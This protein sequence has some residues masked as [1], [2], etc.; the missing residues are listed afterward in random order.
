MTGPVFAPTFIENQWVYLHRTVGS[1][2]KLIPIPSHFYKVII[3]RR[4]NTNNQVVGAFLV[5][6][7]DTV[8]KTVSG[9]LTQTLLTSKM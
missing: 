6:N 5:P 8:S 7:M 3:G 2:P 1:F 9:F 4:K